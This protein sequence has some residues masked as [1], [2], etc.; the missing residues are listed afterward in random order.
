MVLLPLLVALVALGAAR[1]PPP[2]AWWAALAL[3]LVFWAAT[4]LG[5]GP[6]RGPESTRYAFVVVVGLLLLVGV[7]H[8]RVVLGGAARAA[9]VVALVA[10]L[11][12]NLWLLRERGAE[13]R[14]ISDLNR[15]R[16]TMV[17]LHPEE[18]VRDLHPFIAM[19]APPAD[20]L[21]AAERFGAL[22]LPADELGGMSPEQGAEADRLL[23]QIAPPAA[24]GAGRRCGEAGAPQEAVELSAG[25]AIVRSK[26]G[27]T[28][29]ARRFSAAPTVKVGA[30]SPGQPTEVTVAGDAAPQPW[31]L[32]SSAGPL[33]VCE[34]LPPAG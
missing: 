15:A 24:S 17:E 8:D 18:A 2:A 6:L 10:S 7:S 9:I 21:A 1:R 29:M 28:L 27:G 3:L 31:V 30:M 32:T 16:L 25:S 19:P 23:G 14:S 11:A 33:E 13:I 26:S 34:P 22:G 20:Y 4:S 5:Y 12:G